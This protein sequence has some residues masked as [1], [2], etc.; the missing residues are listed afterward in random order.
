MRSLFW[1]HIFRGSVLGWLTVSLWA[2]GEARAPWS[3]DSGERKLLISRR[4][5]SRREGVGTAGKM[6]PSRACP[7][8]PAIHVFQP[9][10]TCL[11]LPPSGP[12]Q[13][14]IDWSGYSSHNLIIISPNISALTKEILGDILYLNRNYIQRNLNQ[15]VVYKHKGILYNL[16]SWGWG[17]S[18]HLLQH[19]WIWRTLW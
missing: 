3:K 6:H 19:E 7:Q 10:S 15:N 17:K 14:R 5:E 12:I 16:K 2:W 1:A 8:W 18:C 11:Q 9:R 4:P 13:T